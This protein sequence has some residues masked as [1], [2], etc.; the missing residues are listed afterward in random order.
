M[1]ASFKESGDSKV[2]KD[3]GSIRWF[4][5][6]AFALNFI[7]FFFIDFPFM[8]ACSFLPG[9]YEIFEELGLYVGIPAFIVV[10]AIAIF[11]HVWYKFVPGND[12]ASGLLLL[13]WHLAFILWVNSVAGIFFDEV[14]S[15]V[16]PFFL[17]GLFISLLISTLFN[18]YAATSINCW[19]VYGLFA[20]IA[21]CP[22][23]IVNPFQWAFVM[24]CFATS[25]LMFILCIIDGNFYTSLPIYG[26]CVFKKDNFYQFGL[27]IGTG[28]VV[29]PL[30][31]I[32][33]IVKYFQKRHSVKKVGSS[34]SG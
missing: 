29:L 20:F 6:R 32:M 4:V 9:Y 24:G 5:M 3:K 12:W 15:M 25:I 27:S 13:V 26:P 11:V 21:V 16:I 19:S 28:W 7:L 34:Q 14:A 10:M 30:W 2:Q 33:S 17:S 22:M 8:V 1:L 31:I 23:I 18:D